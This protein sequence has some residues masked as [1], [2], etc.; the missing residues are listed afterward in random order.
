ME[1]IAAIAIIAVM[2]I[3]AIALY[4]SA[5]R[6]HVANQMMNEFTALKIITKDLFKGAHDYGQANADITYTII[7]SGNV[8][9]S[10]KISSNNLLINTMGGNL[11]VT[12]NGDGSFRITSTQIPSDICILLLT[13]INNWAWGKVGSSAAFTINDTALGPDAAYQLCGTAPVTITLSTVD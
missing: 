2:I 1:L 3:A 13:K 4:D 7:R 10:I 5:N 8:P 11:A 6:T 9:E 12:S